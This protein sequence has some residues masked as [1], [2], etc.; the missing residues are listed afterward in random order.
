M[1]FSTSS[2]ADDGA[3]T[4]QLS[5][6]DL[7]HYRAALSGKA[8]TSD[9][10]ASD[11]VRRVRFKD[12]WTRPEAFRGRRVIIEG[13]VQRCFRQGPIG[14]F[15]ALAEIWV[16]S[17]AGDLF[18]LVVPQENGPGGPPGNADG[19]N[20]RTTPQQVAK[21]GQRVQFTGTFLKT[22]RYA[23]GDSA[24]LAPLIVGN[25]PP[26]PVQENVRVP[27]LGAI[28]PRQAIGRWTGS[29]VYWLL[30]TTLALLAMG[31]L[32]RWHL[33]SPFDRIELRRQ[34]RAQGRSSGRTRR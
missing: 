26:V 23:S 22:I 14:S 12:L 10:G 28:S 32:A 8:S 3:F 9:G 18:C 27:G 20:G 31:M 1:G 21:L 15:P 30:A 17:P 4:N 6:A 7:A 13:R 25:Q 5:L 34:G 19:V 33:R 24:R 2:F 11:Q 29:P 16:A